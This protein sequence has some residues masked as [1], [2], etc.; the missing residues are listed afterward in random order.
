MSLS[1]KF[2]DNSYIK[3][4]ELS[5]D[6]Q[7]TK[8]KKTDFLR[9]FKYD[10]PKYNFILHVEA[11]SRDDPKMIYRMIEYHGMLLRKYEMRVVQLLFY[12][13]KGKSKML[14]SYHD[15]INTLSYELV[16]IQNFSYKTFLETDKADELVLTI[17][18]DYEDKTKEE[19]ADLIFSRAKTIINE[20][21]LKEK[22]VNQVVVLSKLR[23]L[24]GFIQHYIQNTMAL[25]LKIEDTFTF[26][27]GK[28]EG[29]KIGEKRGEKRGEKKNRDKMILSLYKKGKL[30]LVDISDAAEVSV[31][32]VVALI[33]E[34]DKTNK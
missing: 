9:K 21:N 24:D 8:E 12:F 32:Y 15:G 5:T 31:E 11:Q 30:S 3:T 2:I 25:D 13:G 18:S 20:T 22:F 4:E 34:A 6:L 23:N 16:C 26:K 28:L 29:E 14:N 17:L 27:K 10:N 1:K 33:K 7:V 19:I